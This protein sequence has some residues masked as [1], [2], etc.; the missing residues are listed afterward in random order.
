MAL[1]TTL[2]KLL[3]ERAA[4]GKNDVALRQKKLGIWNEITWGAY[5]EK[6]NQLAIAL[7]TH[8]DFRRGDKLAIIGENRPQWL[9]S[10][11]AAQVLGGIAVGIYQESLPHQ[12]IYY[13]NDCKAS[14]VVAE[15]REQVDKLLEIED[16]VPS[17][18]YIIFCNNK[19]LQNYQPNKLYDFNDLLTAGKALMNK[20]ADFLRHEMEQTDCR[21][22][23]VIVYS[24]GTAGT[25]KGIR[26]SHS[27]LIAAAGNLADVDRI[28]KKDD[29]LSFLPLAW[30]YEQVL[31]V[32]MPLTRGMIIN[33]PEEPNTVLSD[34]REIGPHTL[35]APP[36]F[37]QSL[38]SNFTSR[39]QETSWFK[40]KVY[41]TFKKFGDKAAAAT[42]DK[43]SVSA[44]VKFMYILGGFLIF[45]AIRD[46]LG[47]AR[48]KRAY[49]AGEALDGSA[50]TF[51]HSIGVNVKQ[52]Y[53]G[54]ELAG[55]ASVHRD[56]DI[57]AGSAGVPL[58]N[59]E[60]KISNSGEIFVKIPS[61]FTGYS[62]YGDNFAD[63]P[64]WLSLGDQGYI[65]DD[66]HLYITNRANDVITLANGECISPSI[67]ENKLKMSP[68][69]QEAVCFGKGKPYM[70]A[71]LNIDMNTVGRWADQQQIVYTT[72]T[73]LS[74]KREVIQLI[75][76]E[77][78]DLIKQ[79]P[80]KARVKKFIILHKQLNA[81]DEELTW[82]Y[83]VR[84]TYIAEKYRS[85]IDGM[86][87]D[88]NE[89]KVMDTLTKEDGKEVVLETNLQVIHLQSVQEVA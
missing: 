11:L 83:K 48:V 7:S 72:Y 88:T 43:Q 10:H 24:S 50:L 74:T 56:G 18:K 35:L 51:F 37:Y 1:E 4:E 30:I 2:P 79:L 23:A 19:G 63:K 66:G 6:V 41:Q 73:D 3:A 20:K 53:G 21:D 57:Q 71:I 78:A 85:L 25:P 52:S 8:C 82:T 27:N 26:L 70:S 13:L 29:Y 39:I 81:V 49:V 59:T 32:V 75:E 61:L 64:E 89:V 16:Q 67:V 77:V 58:A 65:D 86:Y 22:A 38:I 46:H 5:Y 28:E 12:L 87:S 34:L 68:Y 62:E 14:V 40:K 54:T 69:I 15:D 55:I 9:F 36:R 31:S 17:M 80:Q 60:L 45:S 76:N 33:F 84:R 44:G 42:L 47:L